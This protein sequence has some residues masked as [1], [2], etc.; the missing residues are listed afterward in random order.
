MEEYEYSFIVKDIK[1][2]IN[3]FE[4]NNYKKIKEVEQYRK[5]Y[6]NI[7]NKNIISRITTEDNITVIDFKN[8][9]NKN[10]DLNISSESKS[11]EINEGNKEFFNSMLET[12]D[13]KQTADNHRIRYIYQ[14]D[15]VIIEIDNYIS[16]KMYVV[17]IEGERNKVDKVFK[18]LESI[19]IKYKVIR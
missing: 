16:P 3:Y 19:N 14:K 7:H 8:T 15:N 12:L 6:E 17:A 4:K 10:N 13:F 18:E 1:P 9:S 2:Y 11:L 5:V